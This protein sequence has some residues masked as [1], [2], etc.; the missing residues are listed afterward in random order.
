MTT[1]TIEMMNKLLSETSMGLII[2]GLIKLSFLYWEIFNHVSLKIERKQ[3]ILCLIISSK[4]PNLISPS[5]YTDITVPDD[6]WENS[7]VW[8]LIQCHSLTQNL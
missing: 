8:I 6:Y 5:H 3:E 2:C 7:I 4:P 1:C